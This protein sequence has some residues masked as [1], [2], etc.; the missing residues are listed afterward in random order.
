MSSRYFVPLMTVLFG[1]LSLGCAG[2]C[3]RADDPE[4]RVS[5]GLGAGLFGFCAGVFGRI[6]DVGDHLATWY[7]V[8]RRNA[9]Q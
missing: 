2:F 3:G 9:R 7:A 1:L 6:W 8:G 4:D 5:F